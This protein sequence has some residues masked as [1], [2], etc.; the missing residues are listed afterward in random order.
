MESLSMRHLVRRR[1]KFYFRMWIPVQFAR[2]LRIPE[3]KVSLKTSDPKKAQKRVLLAELFWR[4]LLDKVEKMTEHSSLSEAL[5]KTTLQDYFNNLRAAFQDDYERNLENYELDIDGQ[6][7]GLGELSQILRDRAGCGDYPAWAVDTARDL[8][9]T[10]EFEFTELPITVQGRILRGIMYAKAENFKELRARYL[11]EYDEFVFNSSVSKGDMGLNQV[12]KPVTVSEAVERYM[13]AKN[14]KSHKTKLDYQRVLRW[15]SE[16]VS[17][18]FLIS[19]VSKDHVIQFR[20][21]LQIVPSNYSKHHI[22]KDLT[23]LEIVSIQSPGIS[24]IS[25]RTANKYLGMFRSFLN[26]CEGE[27]II[28]T[29]PGSKIGIK[30]I[31]DP[32]ASRNPFSK[33]QLN[34]IFTAPLYTGCHSLGRRSKPGSFVLKDSKFWIPLVALFTGMRAGEIIQLHTSD[35]CFDEGI[36]FFRLTDEGATKSGVKLGESKTFKTAQSQRC[37]PVHRKLIK[38][39]FLNYVAERGKEVTPSK[40]L[41]WDIAVGTRGDVSDNFSKWFRRFLISNGIKTD[42]TAFHSFRHNFKDALANA[43]IEDSMQDALMGHLEQIHFNHSH[44]RMR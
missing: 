21:F 31:G 5:I 2:L 20:N 29:V 14:Y 18:D 30:V 6:V 37:I 43:N 34:K 26:W 44:I 38:L 19:N 3:V 24:P 42:K 27:E 4:G 32:S 8:F 13:V 22:Y 1:D 7:D 9:S 23:S 33:A 16:L 39:G 35:I 12:K 11:G 28:T 17:A 10:T 40:R 41:F 36:H 25:D 15:F